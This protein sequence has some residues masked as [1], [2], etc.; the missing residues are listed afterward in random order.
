MKVVIIW[1]ARRLG[2]ASRDITRKR[3]VLLA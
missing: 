1:S 2:S 3:V